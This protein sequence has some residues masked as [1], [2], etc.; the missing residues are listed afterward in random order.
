MAK[1]DI[2][3]INFSTIMCLALIA[4]VGGKKIKKWV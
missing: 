2:D 1:F 4:T 3:S